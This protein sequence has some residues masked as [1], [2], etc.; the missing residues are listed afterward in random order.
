MDGPA[1]ELLCFD[2][3]EQKTKTYYPNFDRVDNI[4][5]LWRKSYLSFANCKS[6]WAS[7][8]SKFH[9]KSIYWDFYLDV[10]TMSAWAQIATT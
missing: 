10:A 7:I 2:A 9:S 5:T 6:H 8:K 3:L 1:L 4:K